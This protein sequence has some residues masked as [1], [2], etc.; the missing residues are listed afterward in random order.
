MCGFIFVFNGNRFSFYGHFFQFTFGIGDALNL[1][2]GYFNFMYAVRNALCLFFGLFLTTSWT[3][4]MKRRMRKSTNKSHWKKETN[5]FN[6]VNW[7]CMRVIKTTQLAYAH[8]KY[9]CIYTYKS[10]CCR[11]YVI[12][13][14]CVT[15]FKCTLHTFDE[16]INTHSQSILIIM[17]FFLSILFLSSFFFVTRSS[18]FLCLF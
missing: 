17:F 1:N 14:V 18:L 16:V 13:V 7:I 3:Y 4:L 2:S 11:V 6:L 9:M 8:N 5:S 15:E 12:A 10:L